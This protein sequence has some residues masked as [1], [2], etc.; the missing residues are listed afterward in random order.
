MALILLAGAGYAMYKQKQDGNDGV[1]EFKDYENDPA[2]ISIF[3]DDND[4]IKNVEFLPEELTEGQYSNSLTTITF[5]KGDYLT[6]QKKLENR[7]NEV[8]LKN[9]WIGG[10]LFVK[11]GEDNLKLWFDSKC[12]DVP[13]NIYT[14]YE[15]GEIPLK[16]ATKYAQYNDYIVDFPV[17]VPN[18]SGLVGK[19]HPVLKISIIPDVVEHHE[20]F[21][22]IM[23]QS[24]MVGDAHT[25]YKIYHMLFDSKND[26]NNNSGMINA[27]PIERMNP[28]RRQDVKY[29]IEKYMGVQAASFFRQTNTNI[30]DELYNKVMQNTQDSSILTNDKKKTMLF[31]VSHCWLK[32]RMK[33]CIGEKITDKDDNELSEIHP[34]DVLMSWWFNTSDADIGLIP[35]HL[36]K[37]LTVLD[38]MDAGN[39]N[40]P[41]PFTKFE[42]RTPHQ[43]H[44]SIKKG[45]R[46]TL[47][48]EKASSSLPRITTGYTFAM[49]VDWDKHYSGR[50]WNSNNSETD[51]ENHN[52]RDDADI[53][54]DLHVPLFTNQDFSGLPDKVNLC[55]LFTAEPGRQH[56]VNDDDNDNDNDDDKNKKE[57]RIGMLII[58]AE[59]IC[60]KVI[61]SGIIDDDTESSKTTALTGF[62]GSRRS[63]FI[64]FGD[65]IDLELILQENENGGTKLPLSPVASSTEYT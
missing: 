20:R 21:A 1:K 22:I 58:A 11:P 53:K 49:G 5:Y 30:A 25:Y 35:H 37:E 27:G 28:V 12:K 48:V 60:D 36:R 59:A 14:C 29:H 51:D 42:Y 44:E 55:L 13:P 47:D 15:P 7:I 23:S 64:D 9:P 61:K 34:T 18:L 38:E 4:A 2:I 10:R 33:E 41:I 3:N 52:N 57:A 17:L 45:K 24:H 6:I 62:T 32:N 39:Y 8:L 56:R 26:Q 19:N 50:V 46:V 54:K 65:T 16:R 43:I 31:T 40:T 63:S